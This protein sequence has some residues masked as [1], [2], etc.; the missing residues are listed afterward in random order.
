MLFRDTLH[1]EPLP[2]A[3][4]VNRLL[5]LRPLSQH[6]LAVDRA[7]IVQ[8]NVDGKARH[9]EYEQ[10]E[11]RAAFQGNAGFHEVVTPE[12]VEKIQQADGLFKRFRGQASGRRLT[13]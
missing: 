12:A 13:L 6:D 4:C 3:Y 7:D 9:V 11:C 10:I 2:L 1:D 8:I 5:D